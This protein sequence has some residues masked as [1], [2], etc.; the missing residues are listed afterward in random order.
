[1]A[2]AT[3]SWIARFQYR[4]RNRKNPDAAQAPYPGY[5]FVAPVSA[6]PPGKSFIYACGHSHAAP[7]TPLESPCSALRI[8]VSHS[9]PNTQFF[10]RFGTVL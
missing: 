9:P 5:A 2:W 10:T 8:G 1:M 6:K 3:A 7:R 4:T